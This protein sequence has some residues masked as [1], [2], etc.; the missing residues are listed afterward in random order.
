MRLIKNDTHHEDKAKVGTPPSGTEI[1]PA[2]IS[3]FCGAG[4]MD[5]GFE[6]AGFNVAFAAD[7][8]QAAVT[9]YN[10]NAKRVVAHRIN[11][12]D[13][14]AKEFVNHIRTTLGENVLPRGIIGGPPC[15]G[16]SKANTKRSNNDPRNQL[17]VRYA[18]IVNATAAVYPIEFFVFENVPRISATTT[19]T[20]STWRTYAR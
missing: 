20:P 11:L 15:Q 6:Q 19:V 12:L 7:Y 18:Q 1:R 9:T 8:D 14:S 13:Q 3:L 5:I 4:G 16:F 2:L 17:A 10:H